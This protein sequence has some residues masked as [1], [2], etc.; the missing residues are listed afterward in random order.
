MATGKHLP[1]ECRPD[2]L[3]G[4]AQESVV[5]EREGG[6]TTRIMIY[7]G[8]K[9]KEKIYYLLYGNI[10]K[11]STGCYRSWIHNSC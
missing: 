3:V 9:N 6:P 10:F 2:M 1:A 5:S 11:I 4:W 7:I 8:E